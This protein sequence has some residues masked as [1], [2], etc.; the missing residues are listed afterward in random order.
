[1]YNTTLTINYYSIDGDDSDTTYR[2]QLLE[3]V[4]LPEYTDNVTIKI[5][6]L[7]DTHKDNIYIKQILPVLKTSLQQRLPFEI[8]DKTIFIFLFSFDYFYLTYPFICAI[9]KEMTPTIKL[10][11][12]I[13]SKIN[14][15]IKTK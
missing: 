6:H 13:I 7:F 14:S 4:N 9:I 3:F 15:T 1:M 8:D 2:K 11:E 10:I 12:P 5:E